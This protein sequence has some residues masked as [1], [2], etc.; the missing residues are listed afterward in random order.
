MPVAIQLE[1]HTQKICVIVDKKPKAFIDKDLDS[2]LLAPAQSYINA[3]PK[4]SEKG[5]AAEVLS[6]VGRCVMDVYKVYFAFRGSQAVRR[7]ISAAC[8]ASCKARVHSSYQLPSSMILVS[9]IQIYSIESSCIYRSDL[10][11]YLQNRL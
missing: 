3:Y 8:D 1:E 7:K 9:L 4:L 2:L 5:L 10:F 11:V 6:A